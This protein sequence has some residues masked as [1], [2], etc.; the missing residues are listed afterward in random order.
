MDADYLE[1]DRHMA[2]KRKEWKKFRERSVFSLPEGTHRVDDKIYLR[3]RGNCRTYF[4]RYTDENGK[5]KDCS[6]G[7][8]KNNSL[9]EIKQ[10]ATFLKSIYLFGVNRAIPKR[11]SENFRNFAERTISVLAKVKRWKNPSQKASWQS[12]MS[13]YVYPKIGEKQISDVSRKDILYVLEPIWEKITATASKLRGRLELIFAY[14]IA[15]DLYHGGNPASWKGNLEMNLPPVRKVRKEIHFA[16][17]PY[18]ELKKVIHKLNLSK[19]SGKAV[20]FGILTATRSCEFTQAQWKE[21]DF[22]NRV[23]NCPP[24]RRKDG[25]QEPFRVPLS[26]QA[27]NL[28]KSINRKGS[29]IF[30]VSG[31]FPIGRET[32]RQH[33]QLV[34]GKNYTMHGMRSTFRDW[35]AENLIN[36]VLAEKSLMH[37]T[38]NSVVVAYQRSDLLEQR[39]TVMQSWAD[40]ICEN[41]SL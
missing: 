23:W 10:K 30:T 5:Q 33:V 36:Q 15:E 16:S 41:L 18:D 8:A 38:G 12:T 2:Y 20:L 14:A 22:K 35:C 13:K 37:S 1:E 40:Y 28:L 34:F 31:K 32:A 4:F 7:S 25:K 19:A 24:I 21:I 29:Y 11:K 17:M 9:R 39:R 26:Y 6:L 3:V 27:I